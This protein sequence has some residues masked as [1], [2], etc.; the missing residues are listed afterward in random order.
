MIIRD[1]FYLGF[2]VLYGMIESIA[3]TYLYL[4]YMHVI[5]IITYY[6]IYLNC[7]INRLKL[8]LSP[9]IDFRCNF[10]VTLRKVDSIF[11]FFY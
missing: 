5:F 1:A 3:Y 11:A 4:E 8:H 6:D 7:A 2:D 10:P 9:E